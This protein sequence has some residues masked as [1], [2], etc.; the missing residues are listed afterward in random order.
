MCFGCNSDPLS[1]GIGVQRRRFA[2]DVAWLCRVWLRLVKSGL[3]GL[4][5]IRV[6]QL[7]GDTHETAFKA[8]GSQNA[9]QRHLLGRVLDLIAI[10]ELSLL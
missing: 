3:M 5:A 4:E 6:Q 8:G 1:Q 9:E 2:I 10:A 7:S